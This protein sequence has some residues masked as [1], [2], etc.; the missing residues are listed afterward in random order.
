VTKD[1]GGFNV[2]YPVA[3]KIK[4]DAKA[5]I[6]AEGVAA[7]KWKAV[8]YD[9][10]SEIPRELGDLV[11]SS[12]GSPINLEDKI[13]CLAN[14]QVVPLIWIEDIWGCHLRSLALPEA[15]CTLDSYGVEKISSNPRFKKTEIHK[16]G[17]PA[18][19]RLSR[20]FNLSVAEKRKELGIPAD[21]KIILFAAPG[22]ADHTLYIID[23]L[24]EFLKKQDALLIPRLHPKLQKM[25]PEA[26]QRCQDKIGQIGQNILLF[27]LVNMDDLV[28]ASDIVVSTY[29]TTLV[30]ASY[31]RK[32][33]VSVVS[34]SIRE[35]MKQDLG[36]DT[37]P[38][39]NL[40]C[41]IEAKELSKLFSIDSEVIKNNQQKEMILD[42]NNARR[43]IKIIGR[44]L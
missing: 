4:Q 7:D 15:I 27:P 19:D 26:Y 39:V 31:L 10:I 17:S 29:S 18:F 22:Y 3:E 9:F 25:D 12:L 5:I 32:I 30:D 24:V 34:D 33:P 35:K 44:Y 21:K 1:V 8:G 37:F 23:L 14:K 42:G 6:I 41:G 38:L 28:F 11:V 20:F 2:I 43:V 16:T 13:S 36:E 40:G